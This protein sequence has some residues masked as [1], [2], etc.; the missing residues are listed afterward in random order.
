MVAPF[1]EALRSFAVD[2]G[3]RDP[4]LARPMALLAGGLD[5]VTVAEQTPQTDLPVID[6]HFKATLA[7]GVGVPS[8]LARMV[9]GKTSWA[10]PYPDYG[11]QPDMDI[12]RANYA[13]S[14]VI[15]A[16]EDVISGNASTA[17][18]LSNEVFVGLVL[19]GPGVVYPSHVHKAAEIY[20]VISGTADWQL[21]DVWS[22]HG[23]G[24]VIFHDNGV[25]HATV[26]GDEPQLLLFAWVT[27]PDSIPVIIRN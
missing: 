17:L 2:E 3:D 13:Y 14:P 6:Q 22:T 18:Y 27:D 19:Q 24:A 12:L 7:S 20:W 21:G 8:D 26:T 10:Q 15:G 5:Q 11:C 4:G 1:V 16:A 25:R 23:P 9:E